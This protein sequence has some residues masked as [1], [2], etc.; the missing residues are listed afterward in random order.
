LFE[1]KNIK[2][3]RFSVKKGKG[4]AF[5]GGKKVKKK[6]RGREKPKINQ[7]KGRGSKKRGGKEKQF[8]KVSMQNLKR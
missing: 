2:E 4:G 1:A 7:E 6:Q 5:G 8:Q 3:G